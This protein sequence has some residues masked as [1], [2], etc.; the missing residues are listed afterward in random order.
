[1]SDFSNALRAATATALTGGLALAGGGP[2]SADPASAGNAGAE[3]A[4]TT[5]ANNTLSCLR[6]SNTDVPALY[7]CW[8]AHG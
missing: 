7:Q 2:A 8:R 3:I 5:D 4:W 1:M 6:A